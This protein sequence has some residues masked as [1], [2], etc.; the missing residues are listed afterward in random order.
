M[1]R[2]RSTT[3]PSP[4]A[5][6]THLALAGC[7]RPSSS[8]PGTTIPMG[9]YRHGVV[10]LPA[11]PP[12]IVL[13]A[14]LFLPQRMQIAH[15]GCASH[16]H[17]PTSRPSHATLVPHLAS[18]HAE[19]VTPL[20]ILAPP[21]DT[22]P[23]RKSQQRPACSQ[24]RRPQCNNRLLLKLEPLLC[25]A[26][27]STPHAAWPLCRRHADAFPMATGTHTAVTSH[28]STNMRPLPP[29]PATAT[30]QRRQLQ[31]PPLTAAP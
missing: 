10:N 11:T 13:P 8:S 16:G 12:C 2:S 27:P 4:W 7:S 1:N 24:I 9:H 22:F 15:T 3:D 14:A 17:P 28:H 31:A 5:H 25:C 29:R 20:V 21:T 6:E 30:P 23:C 26:F 19:V 18:S